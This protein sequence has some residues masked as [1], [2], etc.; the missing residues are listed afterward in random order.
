MLA[1]VITMKTAEVYLTETRPQKLISLL[2]QYYHIVYNPGQATDFI[3]R[4]FRLQLQPQSHPALR[5]IVGKHCSHGK[6]IGGCSL[7]V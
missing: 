3:G 5:C 2:P 6:S 1:H 4:H 7:V